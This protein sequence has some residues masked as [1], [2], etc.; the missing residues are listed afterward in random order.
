[1]WPNADKATAL[2]NP[3]PTVAQELDTIFARSSVLEPF[4]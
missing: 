2:L 3:M 4:S 1:M